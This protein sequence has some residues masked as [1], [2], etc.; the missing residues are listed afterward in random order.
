MKQEII[1]P[2]TDSIVGLYECRL[3]DNWPKLICAV[4]ANLR[5]SLGEMSLTAWERNNG[6][7]EIGRPCTTRPNTYCLLLNQ[8]TTAVVR[9]LNLTSPPIPTETISETE[10]NPK[11]L[12][13]LAILYATDLWAGAWKELLIDA[14]GNQF[15]TRDNDGNIYPDTRQIMEENLIGFDD[16]W[17]LILWQL[18]SQGSLTRTGQPLRPFWTID[19]ATQ[20]LQEFINSSDQSGYNGEMMVLTDT[21]N[22]PI[23]FTAYTVTKANNGPALVQK[24]F[25]YTDL[26]LPDDISNQVT[27]PVSLEDLIA[28]LYPKK[29]IGLYLDFAISEKRRGQGLGSQLFDKRI[30]RLLELG[31]EVI[32]GRTI[33]TSPA[34]YYGNYFARG[35]T[36]IAFDPQNPNKAIFAVLKDNI[37]KRN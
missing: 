9:E 28:Y 15:G 34:Q 19:S 23:G 30:D 32:I 18:A 11:L 31:A 16:D 37:I 13:Q 21:E 25:P 33:K 26:L 6:Q 24:R 14:Q 3:R 5:V 10:P 1:K 12:N 22:R 8:V 7:T 20:A 29:R 35:M 2:T 36:P 17:Q 27:N 4:E